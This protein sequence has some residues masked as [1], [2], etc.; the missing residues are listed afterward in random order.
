IIALGA[1]CDVWSKRVDA[2]KA[3]IEKDNATAKVDTYADYQKLIE[4]KDIDAVVIAT[5]DPNHASAVIA[6][7]ESGKHVYCEKP[8]SRYLEE[9]FAVQDT[10]QK[11]GKILTL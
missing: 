8:V 6:A 9:V 1:L 4:R 3:L 10:V 11:T 5:H 2:V 7:L